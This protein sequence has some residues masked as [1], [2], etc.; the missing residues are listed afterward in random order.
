MSRPY[1]RRRY[2]RAPKS[3]VGRGFRGTYSRS[4]REKKYRDIGNDVAIETGATGT[5]NVYT[6]NGVAQ[7]TSASQRVGEV[8]RF[9]K[10]QIRGKFYM[11]PTVTLSSLGGLVKFDIVL[12]RSPNGVLPTTQDIYNQA[13]PSGYINLANR[14]RFKILMSCEHAIQPYDADRSMGP[15]IVYFNKM[16]KIS[17]P[18]V[19]S[20]SGSTISDIRTCGIFLVFRTDVASNAL[21]V[22]FDARLRYID[23]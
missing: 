3:I 17:I 23:S 14:D 13:D 19:Y 4:P 21:R 22:L 11:I 20:G 7:G 9:T 12:D 15:V 16:R 10:L 2:N 18:T 1:K 5:E 6:L 8:A